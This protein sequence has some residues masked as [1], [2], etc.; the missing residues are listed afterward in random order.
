MDFYSFFSDDE[1]SEPETLRKNVINNPYLLDWFFTVRVERF[2][3][4]WLYEVI[5]AIWGWYRF[6]Y[7][8]MRG[9]VHCH[10]LAK[11]RDDTGLCKLTEISLNV[12]N[13]IKCF[14]QTTLNYNNLTI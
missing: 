7:A 4:H 14:F 11:L 12:H 3:E 9:S 2:V 1:L 13:S 6:T 10:G 8:L 5:G